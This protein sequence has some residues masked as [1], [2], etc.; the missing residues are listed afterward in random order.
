MS[1]VMTQRKVLV[2]NK[3]WNPI[4]IVTL[5]RAMSLICSSYDEKGDEPKAKIMDPTMEFKDYTWKEWAKLIPSD[6]EPVI[7]SARASFR[8]PEIVLLQRY[9][10]LPQQ[11]VHFSR[12]TI[13]R[14]DNNQCKYCNSRPGTSEL[15]I[16]H[17]QPRSKGGKTTWENC[18]LACTACNRYKADLLPT[19]KVVIEN[20][21][22]KEKGVDKTYS[23]AVTYYTVTFNSGRKTWQVTIKEP[24]KPRFTF[25][26]GDYRCKSWESILGEMYWEIELRNENEDD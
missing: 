4:A 8:I 16:D 13:Y 18:V 22:R 3:G 7:R 1:G 14:R 5:E 26:K 11:R 6:D 21:I 9:N 15:S 23:V 17:I 25:Y 24:K 19:K 10:M 12:R 2:L 20:R